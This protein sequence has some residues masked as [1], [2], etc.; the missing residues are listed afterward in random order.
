M[1]SAMDAFILFQI[2]CFFRC[3]CFLAL[4][5][6]CRVIRPLI[7][8][9]CNSLLCLPPPSLLISLFYKLHSASHLILF[10]HVEAP[11]SFRPVIIVASCWAIPVGVAHWVVSNS[12]VEIGADAV[13]QD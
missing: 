1:G 11:L 9:L 7:G 12:R 10:L 3:Q 5:G 6:Q 4:V 2:G 8:F 13:C